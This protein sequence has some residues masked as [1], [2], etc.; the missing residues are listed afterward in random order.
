MFSKF[1]YWVRRAAYKVQFAA[2]RVMCRASFARRVRVASDRHLVEF[3]IEKHR[4]SIVKCH[5][6]LR[7]LSKQLGDADFAMRKAKGAVAHML[8]ARAQQ[9]RTAAQLGG[10]EFNP[11]P[12]DM[13]TWLTESSESANLITCDDRKRQCRYLHMRID[14]IS[15]TM[16][17]LQND[18]H[19]LDKYLADCDIA[20]DLESVTKTLEEAKAI[21]LDKL[22]NEILKN[23][24]KTAQRLENSGTEDESERLID[25]EYQK[26]ASAG[27]DADESAGDEIMREIIGEFSSSLQTTKKKVSAVAVLD[28]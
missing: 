19:R 12:A 18:Q 16:R 15:N 4:S 21:N 7:D 13:S 6:K 10:F 9:K 27:A 25:E 24:Q 11:S 20:R 3:H 23:L 17:T 2:A 1:K 14:A 22:T 28:C 5:E 26:I 8:R